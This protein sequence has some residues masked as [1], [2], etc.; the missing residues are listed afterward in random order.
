VGGINWN[1]R[2]VVT[3]I[4]NACIANHSGDSRMGEKSARGRKP[5]TEEK[6]HTSDKQQGGAG[7]VF[8]EEHQSEILYFTQAK[9]GVGRGKKGV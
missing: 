6:T 3:T 1:G 9:K 8:L 2:I 4:G 5:M 7:N